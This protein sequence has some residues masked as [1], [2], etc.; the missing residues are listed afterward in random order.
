MITIVD[1]GLGNLGSI[2]N[3]LRKIGFD[4]IISGDQADIANATKLILPGVGAFDSGMR[5][6]KQNGLIDILNTKALDE[7]VPVLGI[8]LGAQLMTRRSDE[9]DEPGLGWF[10]A[11]TRKMQFDGI[12]GRWPLPNI[13]WRD[14]FAQNGYGLLP[15]PTHVPP[16]YYF[17]HSYFLDADSPDIVSVTSEYGFE[18]ACGLSKDNLHCVQFHPEKSHI[19]GKHLLKSFAELPNT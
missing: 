3:M 17:V 2:K 9:G 6:L 13:G 14:V 18:F 11:E 15:D 4:A 19:F 10:A 1:Y 12:P 16:R 8:C 7:R 5:H